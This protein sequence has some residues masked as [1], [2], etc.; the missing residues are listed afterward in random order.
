MSSDIW[1]MLGKKKGQSLVIPAK[2]TNNTQPQTTATTQPA[3]IKTP[4]VKPHRVKKVQVQKHVHQHNA[5]P[6]LN[7]FTLE[8]DGD[9]NALYVIVM[10]RNQPVYRFTL[11]KTDYGTWQRM[12]LH[13]QRMYVQIRMDAGVFGN[14]AIILNAVIGAIIQIL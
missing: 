13:Q 12:D 6:A 5:Q 8:A 3:K 10:C 14:N 4:K 2:K 7:D 11:P 1:G 9:I